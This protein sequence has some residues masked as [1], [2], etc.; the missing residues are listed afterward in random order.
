MVLLWQQQSDVLFWQKQNFQQALQIIWE[1]S[2]LCCNEPFVCFHRR[3]RRAES[4][5]RRCRD[6]G[7]AGGHRVVQ[8]NLQ[9]NDWVL[10][11]HLCQNPG[12][13]HS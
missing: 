11:H 2:R 13:V 10:P 3:S 8:R 9:R 6:H 1:L 7:G 5:S 4:E 12:E